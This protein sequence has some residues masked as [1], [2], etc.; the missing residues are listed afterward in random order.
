MGKLGDGG[1]IDGR[2]LGLGNTV[3]KRAPHQLTWECYVI[4]SRNKSI[5]CFKPPKF[6]LEIVILPCINYQ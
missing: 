1:D 2:V 3:W 6:D 4:W 5:L